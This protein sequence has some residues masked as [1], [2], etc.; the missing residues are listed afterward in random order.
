[1]AVQNE[2]QETAEDGSGEGGD[3][4]QPKMKLGPLSIQL[5]HDKCKFCGI[6]AANS[7][8]FRSHPLEGCICVTC[9]VRRAPK[10]K[11]EIFLVFV[12]SLAWLAVAW[13]VFKHSGAV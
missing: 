2:T 6:D 8:L 5:M 11:R 9:H 12:Q 13:H 7:M 3:V 4:N 1:M 10:T